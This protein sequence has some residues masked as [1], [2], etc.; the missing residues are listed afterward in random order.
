VPA[1]A[2]EAIRRGA[3]CRD[4]QPGQT[5]TDQ[6]TSSV[7]PTAEGI[8]SVPSRTADHRSSRP[9]EPKDRQPRLPRKPPRNPPACGSGNSRR[10]A[11]AGRPQWGLGLGAV[12]SNGHHIE[13]VHVSSM[14]KR[15]WATRES[16][17]VSGAPQTRPAWCWRQDAR[18]PTQAALRL[19]RKQ[20][21]VGPFLLRQL[22]RSRS[23]WVAR[24]AN[25][26]VLASRPPPVQTR[27]G[28]RRQS[29][30]A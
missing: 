26:S 4:E 13:S 10:A 6:S 5:G 23:T 11:A 8:A 24:P 22:S 16:R 19:G 21:L 25:E 30:R 2:G 27:A 15:T 3:A 20:E 29:R 18:L 14:P 9:G 1:A 28:Q 7:D 17:K 12:R